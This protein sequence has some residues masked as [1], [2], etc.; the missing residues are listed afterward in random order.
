MTSYIL[1]E[2][3]GDTTRVSI[4]DV[5]TERWGEFLTVKEIARMADYSDKAVY[6]H[7]YELKKIG[8][9]DSEPG[10]TTKYALN[11]EDKRALTLAILHDEEYLRKVQLSVEEIEKE[12][13]SK[14]IEISCEPEIS[15]FDYFKSSI[16]DM[17]IS[18]DEYNLKA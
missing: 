4:L 3:F 17:I 7:I 11:T 6:N 16:K 10:R 1:K 9:V 8:I 5:L 12:E 15:G 14:E 2:I 13:L 18:T